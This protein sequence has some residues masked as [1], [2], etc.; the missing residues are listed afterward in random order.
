MVDFA[1][2]PEPATDE[3]SWAKAMKESAGDLL[4]DVAA[5]YADVPWQADALRERLEAVGT[6]YGLS[7]GKAQAPVRVAVTG[8][9]VG[10]PLFESLAVL[11]RTETLRRIDSARERVTGLA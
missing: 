8:R 5:A 3:A 9:T 11:G 6:S 1:F 4:A 10:L 2:L 7:L